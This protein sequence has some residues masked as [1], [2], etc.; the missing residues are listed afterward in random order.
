MPSDPVKSIIWIIGKNLVWV[1]A[2]LAHGNPKGPKLR[3][4]SI[5][6]QR[7]GIIINARPLRFISNQEIIQP[8]IDNKNDK[9]N[10]VPVNDKNTGIKEAPELR[11][12]Q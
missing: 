9:Y 5:V 7:N 4:H 11:P 12:I 6:T 8:K 3:S 2:K 10:T 1:I